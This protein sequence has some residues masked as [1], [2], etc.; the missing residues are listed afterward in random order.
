MFNRLT[1]KAFV[2]FVTLVMIGLAIGLE[3]GALPLY[4][5]AAGWTPYPYEAL[6]R[7][8]MPGSFFNLPAFVGAT[9]TL[10]FGIGLFFAFM[11]WTKGQPRYRE[12]YFDEGWPVLRFLLAA[13]LAL[14]LTYT[15]STPNIVE[16]LGR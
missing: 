6:A 3:A 10:G 9:S 15:L 7:L 14:I 2:H 11:S 5:V 4:F 8:Y 1:L 16:S 13:T 12:D